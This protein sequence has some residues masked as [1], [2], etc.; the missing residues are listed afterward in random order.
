MLQLG[1]LH[2]VHLFFVALVVS[3]IANDSVAIEGE[4]CAKGGHNPQPAI[5][6]DY[7]VIGAGA[8]GMAFVDT[9]LTENKGCS[10]VICDQR[11]APGGHWVDSYDFVRLHQVKYPVKKMIHHPDPFLVSFL[12]LLCTLVSATASLLRFTV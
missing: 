8:M 9:L 10:V 1:Q 3:T 12:S 2:L 6:C 5:E 7:L 4:E 11:G